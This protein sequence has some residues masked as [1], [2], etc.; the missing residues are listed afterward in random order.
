MET[1]NRP[2]EDLKHIR[3]MMEASSK[4]LSL[5][6]LSGIAVG[7]FALIGAVLAY[8][9]LLHSGNVKYDDYLRLLNGSN[10]HYFRLALVADGLFVLVGALVSAYV[11][12]Y[13]KSKQ[14][15][16]AFWTPSAKNM[17]ISLFTVLATGGLFCLTLIINGS[18]QLIAAAMLIFYGLALLNAAK[19]S[20]HDLHILAYTQIFLGLLAAL[21]LNYGLFLWTLG[22]GVVHI[23]YGIV[24]YLKYEKKSE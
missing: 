11:I 3:Q 16:V 19:Y 23:L 17:V 18:I 15:G 6:G 7:S 14:Q 5:S 12:S 22:F 13:R 8:L 21:L 20:K 10:S 9:L 1:Q 24:M 4:F 2:N